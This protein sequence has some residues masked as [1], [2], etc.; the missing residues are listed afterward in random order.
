MNVTQTGTFQAVTRGFIQE[1][2]ESHDGA[3]IISTVTVENQHVT[4]VEEDQDLMV[5]VRIAA[6]YESLVHP[7][8]FDFKA[9]VEDAIQAD[10]SRLKSNLLESGDTFFLPLDPSYV[11]TGDATNPAGYIAVIVCSIVASACAVVAAYYAIRRSMKDSNK[12]DKL[13]D[14]YSEPVDSQLTQEEVGVTLCHSKSIEIIQVSESPDK[15]EEPSTEVSTVD[16]Q[17]SD[18]AHRTP[19]KRNKGQ[20]GVETINGQNGKDEILPS[21]KPRHAGAMSPNTMEAGTRLGALAESILRSESF[22]SSL[23]PPTE[24]SRH[25]YPQKAN[26]TDPAA[27]Y[28]TATYGLK[29]VEQRV[30]ISSTYRAC[31]FRWISHAL[32]LHCMNMA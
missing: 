9:I 28:R 27:K 13:G 6:E 12:G 23:D 4:E 30:S 1:N 19:K 3:V 7:D 32:F 15:S 22:G 31:P 14:M 5:E 20:L 10:F 18:D 21:N 26:K 2:M 24:S 29:R 17:K 16:Y 25:M 8:N 11:R